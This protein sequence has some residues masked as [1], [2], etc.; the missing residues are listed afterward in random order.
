[1]QQ[2]GEVI[3]LIS[4]GIQLVFELIDQLMDMKTGLTVQRQ[5]VFSK[6]FGWCLQFAVKGIYLN[7]VFVINKMPGQFFQLSDIAQELAL[8]LW[9][10]TGIFQLLVALHCWQFNIIRQLSFDGRMNI[11]LPGAKE[12]PGGSNSLSGKH[13]SS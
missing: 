9:E 13:N 1:M 3:V 7:V 5:Q 4:G 10:N 8:D 6:V 12:S 2:A 11:R